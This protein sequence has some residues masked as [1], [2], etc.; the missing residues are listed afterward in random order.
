MCAGSRILAIVL[1]SL[2]STEVTEGLSQ[3]AAM[4]RDFDE[5]ANDEQLMAIRARAVE[6][7]KARDVRQLRTLIADDAVSGFGSN[8]RPGADALIAQHDLG[9]KDSAIWDELSVI[10]QFGGGFDTLNRDNF[11]MPY[12]AGSRSLQIE[13][14]WCVVMGNVPARAQPRPD[15]EVVASLMSDLLPMV[16]A[17]SNAQWTAVRAEENLVAFVPRLLCRSGRD[18]RAH[19]GKTATGWK[20]VAI[21]GGD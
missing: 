15:A 1:F 21:I 7:V 20:I 8:S 16:E 14:G 5:G 17:R 11:V 10:L 19:F 2:I 18:L 12:V 9:R 4:L 3:R 13:V 6:A